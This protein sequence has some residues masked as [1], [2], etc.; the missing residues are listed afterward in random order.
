MS[1]EIT[2]VLAKFFHDIATITWIGGLFSM[3]FVVLPSTRKILEKRSETR[4]LMT[5]IQHRLSILVYISIILLVITGLMLAKHSGLYLG[6]ISLGNEYSTITNVKHVL[7]ISMLLITLTRSLFLDKMKLKHEKK[8]KVSVIL[9]F[10]NITLGF[11]VI[12]LS[13]V[14]ASIAGSV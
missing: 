3:G 5:T 1:I 2:Y 8:E 10:S 11:I 13:A 9:L 4:K 7:Y 12:F 14:L 6:V